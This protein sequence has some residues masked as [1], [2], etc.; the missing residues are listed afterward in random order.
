[1][2]RFNAAL[3]KSA[4]LDM[5]AIHVQ[6]E[7]SMKAHDASIKAMHKSMNDMQKSIDALFGRARD[8]YRKT[9]EYKRMNDEITARAQWFVIPVA[10][11]TLFAVTLVLVRVLV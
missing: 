8:A 5:R 4:T 7:Q 11:A 10:G 6:M 3:N 2:A 1:M 9:P